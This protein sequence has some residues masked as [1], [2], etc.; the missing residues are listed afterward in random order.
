MKTWL[1]STSLGIALLSLGLAACT[2]TPKRVTDSTPSFDGAV[3]NSGFIGF[4]AAG[5]GIL[6]P[7]ARERYNL[8]IAEFG[9]RYLPP[10]RPDAGITPT[11]TNTYL[12]A[13]QYLVDFREMNRWRKAKP[14]P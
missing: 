12:I 9:Q 14:T 2:V 11:S 1:N 3:R 8:L 6:T 4:D 7:L 13:P 10:L 5:N